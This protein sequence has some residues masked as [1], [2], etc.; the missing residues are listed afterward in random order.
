MLCF[1]LKVGATESKFVF[2]SLAFV[3]VS[4][5]LNS[6]PVRL[7]ANGKQISLLTKRSEALC[8]SAVQANH[9]EKERASGF[10]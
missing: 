3:T 8:V 7:F 1:V 5:C 9:A 4:V 10:I 2:F 6:H